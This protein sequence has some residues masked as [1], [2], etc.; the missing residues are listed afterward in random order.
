MTPRSIAEISFN[1]P[2][3]SPI[4]VRLPPRIKTSLDILR[5]TFPLLNT[6]SEELNFQLVGETKR[7]ANGFDRVKDRRFQISDF[8]SQISDSRGWQSYQLINIPMT[9]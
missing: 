3:Y 2:T 1:A 8:R 7:L 4:G 5:S 6:G 9:N